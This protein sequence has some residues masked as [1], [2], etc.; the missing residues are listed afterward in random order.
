[1][2]PFWDSGLL[3]ELRFGS[4]MLWSGRRADVAR[5]ELEYHA[6]LVVDLVALRQS[7]ALFE[8]DPGTF[9]I[10][11]SPSTVLTFPTNPGIFH[12]HPEPS[13]VSPSGPLALGFE[14]SRACRNR[15][16]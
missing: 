7:L 9:R 12:N 5:S 15:Q 14:F 1:M 4:G 16:P 13:H 10:L 3:G 6:N 2:R 8:R 11:A